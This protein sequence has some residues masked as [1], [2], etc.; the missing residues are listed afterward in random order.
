MKKLFALVLA[1]ALLVPMV[2]T[3]VAKA[4]D[5]TKEPF[6]VLN[7][8]AVNNEKFPHI[9]DLLTT[10]IYNIGENARF[11]YN[12]VSLLYGSYTDDELTEMAQAM[13]TEMDRRPEGMRYWTIF[14]IAQFMKI[15]AQ[16]VLF[17][18]TA[19]EQLK[20]ITTDI[21]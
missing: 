4:E 16:N 14:G 5:F 19:I 1:L 15:H 20:A 18:D 17:F 21:L 12:G 6:Y 2:L 9:E 11:A 7:W 8:S 13:K 10:T 3:P